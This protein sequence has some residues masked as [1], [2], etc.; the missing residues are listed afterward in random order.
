MKS[1]S[2]AIFFVLALPVL[3]ARAEVFAW[4]QYVADRVEA[5]AITD[6]PVCP[7]A[8][9]DGT[10]VN[11]AVRAGPTTAYPNTVCFVV[12]P[13]DS[14]SVSVGRIALPVPTSSPKRIAVVGDTGCRLKGIYV[15]ACNDPRQ[16]PFRKVAEAIAAQ[17][18]DLIIH[19]GDY[20]YRETPCPALDAGCAKSPH[21]DI[22]DA[23]RADF[24]APAAALL[25][26]APW[27]MVRGNHEVCERGG[28]GWTRTLE[29]MPFDLT[30]PC[31]GAAPPFFVPLQAMTL[32]VIDT[33]NAP[34]PIVGSQV[35]KDISAQYA[36]LAD[37]TGAP[38]WMLQHRPIWS[39]GGTVAGL[40]FGDN[41]TLAAAARNVL[42]AQV[43]LILSGH[44]HIFQ[45]LSYVE[46]LPVQIVVG[47]GGDYLNPGRSVDPA[48]WVINGVT[49]KHGIHHVA[50][51]GF[52]MMEADAATGRWAVTNFDVAGVAL[53]RCALDGRN[54]K[55]SGD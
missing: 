23:W 31:A 48:G 41:K 15:Q 45:V 30:K 47:H 6:Q 53:Q 21:G 4:V 28:V 5:R 44:H 25:S 20:H 16:W 10:D 24:F 35:S 51:F 3:S 50:Q 7:S 34:E 1:G 8:S 13:K 29:A 37:T 17:K 12:V 38:I 14:V 39:A 18:P 55:C 42:P 54:A 40:P 2:V 32:A 43:Q 46:N 22:W 33:S 11:M 52:A 26:S 36:R 49:I 19:V 27:V 9:V